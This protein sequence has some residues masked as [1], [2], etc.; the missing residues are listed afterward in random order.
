MGQDGLVYLTDQ[1]SAVKALIHEPLYR[2]ELAVYQRFKDAGLKRID[3]F[4]IPELLGFSDELCVIEMTFVSAPF[5]LDFAGAT[6][7][8]PSACQLD[9]EAQQ[10]VAERFGDDWTTVV[11]MREQM[12][13]KYGIYLN[14]VKPGNVTVRQD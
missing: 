13:N 12:K 1:P 4:N 7:D 11:F 2:R 10:R 6:I 8:K 9:I 3:I 14:D 5:V